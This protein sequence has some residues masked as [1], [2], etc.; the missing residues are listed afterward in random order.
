MK[1]VSHYIFIEL[2]IIVLLVT[3]CKEDEPVDSDP[4]GKDTT[5]NQ[6]P[7]PFHIDN[8]SDTYAAIADPN[9]SSQWGPYNLHDP[10]VIRD[11][12]YFY[13]YSTDVAYGATVRAGLQVRR[14]KDLVEWTFRGWVFPELPAK[15]AA[16]IRA[17]GGQPNQS[18]WAPCVVKV[19]NTFRLYYSLAST[20]PRLSVIGMATSSSPDGPWS[21]IGI[22]VTSLDNTTL[23]TNA[24]DPSVLIDKTGNHWM[25]YGSAWDGIYV[26]K[27]DPATG[28]AS[29]DGDKGTRIAQRGFTGQTIN[30]NIE[31]PDII[32]NEELDMYFL[33]ISYDWLETKYNVRVARS[34]SPDGPFLDHTGSDINNV[35]DD[36][37]MIIASY[38]FTDHGGWQG[39]GHSSMFKNGPRYFIAHQGRPSAGK[40]FMVMHVREVFWIEGWP[41]VSPERYAL[42]ENTPVAVEEIT[43]GWDRVVFEY[44]VVPGF[45]ETQTSPGTQQSSPLALDANGSVGGNSSNSWSFDYPNLFIQWSNGTKDHLIVHRGRDWENKVASTILFTGLDQNGK[46]SWGRKVKK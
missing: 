2:L 32:Y 40:Y 20:K 39:T 41:V 36:L 34:S 15:G 18:L 46:T 22:V 8:L 35:A 11:G 9:L 24:I 30:G 21:E 14:S 42:V 38:R 3:A 1:P 4:G 31:A 44:S 6:V 26:L 27:L 43:G 16:F 45:A 37:P 33:F 7:E 10:A 13:S 5:N 29:N 17:N 28:L 12:E 23:Q 25:Y 19:G